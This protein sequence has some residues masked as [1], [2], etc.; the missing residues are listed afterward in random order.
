M[1]KKM[2][3]ILT[4][5]LSLAAF[6]APAFAQA[7]G[8]VPAE[9][10]EAFKKQAPLA[11]KDIDSYIKI[12]G[13]MAAVQADPSKAADIYKAE[14]WDEIRVSYVATKISLAQVLETGATLEQLGMKDVPEVML[15]TKAEI[16][17]VKKNQGALQKAAMDAAAA[18]QKQ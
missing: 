11:Q 18:M 13:Q 4:A 2:M 17:L 10:I 15:P 6:S 12:M 9:M 5:A 1:F 8:Q 14:G 16:E 3:L 7:P